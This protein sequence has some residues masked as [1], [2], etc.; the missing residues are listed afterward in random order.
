ML[1]RFI[2]DETDYKIEFN[3]VLAF[4]MTGEYFLIIRRN[5]GFFRNREIMLEYASAKDI[6]IYTDDE[7][8]LNYASFDVDNK[9]NIEFK[10][11]K[12][13]KFIHITQLH[14]NLRRENDLT[15]MYQSKVFHDDFE[16]FIK[17]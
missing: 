9:Y 14:P 13:D 11:P 2:V 3:K 1:L 10:F 16:E 12:C 17:N 4:N 5:N 15:K 6:I 8:M 7:T